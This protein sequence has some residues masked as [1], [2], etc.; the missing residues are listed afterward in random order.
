MPDELQGVESTSTGTERRASARLRVH[1]LLYVE[2][3]EKN[4]GIVTTINENGLALAAAG[5]LGAGERQGG[6]PLKMR[7]QLPGLPGGIEAEGRI[8]WR[9]ESRKEAGVSFVELGEKSREQLRRWISAQA[10]Q[11]GVRLNQPEFPRTQQP[12]SQAA[13][14]RAARVSFADV[15]SSRVD[16]EETKPVD[17]PEIESTP[18]MF[19]PQPVEGGEFVDATRI[20]ASAF[21]SATFAEEQ[22]NAVRRALND[23]QPSTT[24]KEERQK[25]QPLSFLERRLHARRQVLLFTYAVLGEDNGGLVFNLGESG[26]ALTAAVT[27]RDDHFAKMRVRFPDSEDWIHTQGRLA[28]VSD[29]GKEAGIEFVNLPDEARIRI[30]EWVSLGEATSDFQWEQGRARTSQ[31]L[32]QQLPTLS[33]PEGPVL[34]PGGA[35]LSYEERKTPVPSPVLLVSGVKG[36]LPRASVRKPVARI[37]PPR[38]PDHSVRPIVRVAR[39]ALM[40][41]AVSTL[42]ATSWIFL[43]RSHSSAA[44]GTIAQNSPEPLV[45]GAPSRN[46]EVDARGA[47]A[48]LP[49]KQIESVPSQPEI[50]KPLSPNSDVNSELAVKGNATKDTSVAHV[51]VTNPASSNADRAERKMPSPQ[52]KPR[53]QQSFTTRLARPPETKP[54]EN[55]VLENR[56]VENKA[57]ESK[58]VENRTFESKLSEKPLRTPEVLATQ[59]KELNVAPS[60]LNSP[61][62]HPE[63]TPAMNAE[64]ERAPIAPKQPEIPVARTPLVTVSFDPYP[65]IRMP[66]EENPKKSG[67]GKSLQ[68]GHLL[69]RVDPLYPE[70]AKQQGVEGEVKLHAIFSREGTVESLISVSG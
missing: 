21:E 46:T 18:K 6:E 27:L 45:R 42:L 48:D 56:V 26:L 29:S 19:P 35:A 55:K 3:G 14:L 24:S 7:I 9:S 30:R 68:M 17:L 66:K 11:S 62:N 4:G 15:A 5:A 32:P 41:A 13:K 52:Q 23:R 16:E 44:R 61:S 28:W 25:R 58:P 40:T 33:E 2:L 10:A 37:K 53:L 34:E 59:N 43:Q 65:S 36:A 20:V 47:A 31:G 22:G 12:P 49:T 70:E 64:K 50:A 63:A 1:S 39:T 51:P 67:K 38:Q 60:A 8:V 69:A 57:I 54:K